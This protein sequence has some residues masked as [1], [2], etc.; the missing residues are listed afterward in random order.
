M[1][2]KFLI[3]GSGFNAL[4]TACYLK[5]K[6]NDV[7]IIFERNIKGVLGSVVIE[8][9]NFDL[10]YQFFDGLDKE[11]DKFIRNMFENEDLHDFKY[12]ASTFS[13]DYFYGDHAIPYWPSYGKIFILK[14]FIHYLFN[15]FKSFFINDEVKVNNLSDLY[16]K[17]PPNIRNIISKGCEKHYQI[18]PEELE[19]A[20]TEMSTYTNFRQTIFN[21]RVSNF[22]KK[23]SI[24]FDKHLASRRKTN[25]NLDN[26][27]LY[28]KGKNMEFV[29]DKL[30]E[31]LKNQG[32]IF[33]KSNFDDINLM[34]SQNHVKYNEEKFDK[35][36]ITTSLGNT[37]RLLNIDKEKSYEHYISQVFIYF[38]VERVNFKFQYTQVNDINLFCSRISNCSLYS[39]KTKEDNYILIAEIPLTADN[40]IWEDDDKLRNIAWNEIIKCGIVESGHNYTTAKVLKIQKTF[41]VPKINFF[42]FLKKIE[43]KLENQ[44]FGNVSMIGQGFFTRRMFVKE[45]LKK[46]S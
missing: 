6:N 32:V 23:N 37:Q 35:A 12:G 13:N 42:N 29:T 16:K 10:G 21:D 11:S 31:R 36:I 5:I 17:I 44:F 40:K 28:P 38:A 27:S 25:N 2:Q 22:L 43:L 46:L 24:F 19:T 3:I 4:A 30:I 14:A 1:K 18:K 20:A 39:K 34:P 15:F 45:L 26:I 8:N 9:E 41:P 7:K 33:E